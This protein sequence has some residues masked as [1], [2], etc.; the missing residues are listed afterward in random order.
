VL[1]TNTNG[2]AE[3][4][5]NGMQGYVLKTSDAHE[6][7]NRLAQSRPVSERNRMGMKAAQTASAFTLDKHLSE[8]LSLYDRIRF[9][10]LS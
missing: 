2:A 1:T 10:K 3:L 8:L 4:I 6:L 7:A 5:C 9:K